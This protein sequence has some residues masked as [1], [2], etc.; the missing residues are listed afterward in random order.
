VVAK[1]L[2]YADA[3]RILGHRRSRLVVALDAVASA[4]LAAWATAA[5][6]G[7]NGADAGIPLN[8]FELKN[9][10][11]RY[12]QALAERTSDWRSGLSR[13]DRT[14]RLAAAH[15]VLV[16]TA[17][18]EALEL[19]E[20][21]V[22]LE[23]LALTSAE[24]VAQATGER[25]PVGYVELIELLATDRLPLPE[26]HRPYTRTRQEVG[27]A[28]TRLAE[29]VASFARGLGLWEELD[30]VKQRRMHAAV[31]GS[32][33]LKTALRLYDDSYRRLAT[34]NHE[35]AMWASL[36]QAHALGAELST[37]A[38]LLASAAER[39][40]GNRTHA[41]LLEINRSALDEPVIS[42]AQAPEGVVLPPLR[43]AY[44]NPSCR[45]AEVNP[46]D[47]PAEHGWW[48]NQNSIPDVETLLA[49]YLVSPRA[50]QA[51]LVV[52]GEPGS[53]KSK[54]TEVLAARL[55]DSDFLPIRVELRTVPAESMIHEQIEHAVYRGPGER[56]GLHDLLEAAQG[57]LPVVMLDGFDE[58][59]QASGV[60]RYDYL[61][62]VR[63]FQR[64]QARIGRPVAVIVTSRTVVADRVRFPI[65]TLAVRLE[66][67][68][69]TQVRRWLDVWARHNTDVLAARGLRPLPAETALAHS[70]LAG[71]PLLLMLLAL[72]DATDNA[73]QRNGAGLGPAELYEALLTDFALREVRRAP[74]NQGLSTARQQE[75]AERE[76][77]RLAVV[78]LSMFSRRRQS[79]TA[80]ELD[81]DLPVLFREDEDRERSRPADDV[82][83]A[84]QRAIGRF[85][86]LHTSEAT[87]RGQPA[88]SYEFLHATFGEFL[89][90]WLTVRA[91][92]DLAAV[93]QVLRRGVTSTGEHLDDGFLHA[94][95]S[96]SGLAERRP[97][98]DFLTELLRRMTDR[99]RAEIR[100]LIPL[101][102]ADS[103][104]PSQ[105]RAFRDYEPVRHPI[106]RRLA[107]YS[108][109][110]TLLL[111]LLADEWVDTAELFEKEP[112]EDWLRH[113]GLWHGQFAK[114]EWDGLVDVVRARILRTDMQLKVILS[115]EDGS[116]VAVRDVLALLPPE[117]SH[118]RT[119]Y[120]I[121]ISDPDNAAYDLA[122]PPAAKSGHMIREMAYLPNW[123]T[124]LL[125]L[126]SI[127]A[128]RTTPDALR[129]HTE[130]ERRTA[131]G[132]RIAELDY[133]RDA[134]PE[135]RVQLYRAAFGA[136]PGHP[137]MREQLLLRLRDEI[138]GLPPALVLDLLRQPFPGRPS[139][140]HLAAV[141]ALWR[142]LNQ[143]GARRD[144]QARD[145]VIAL[146]KSLERAAPGTH[147]A[148]LSPDLL[149][150][151]RGR[152]IR[153][154]A[155]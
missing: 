128:L 30:S 126:H 8:L 60:N 48:R 149:S 44:V 99:E 39:S 94:A 135:R 100:M 145:L 150:A 111:V 63:D 122:V 101:L 46:G 28:H 16:V 18:F 1:P 59:L 142:R 141:D 113:T 105:N 80:A 147:L 69:E 131:P 114:A 125:L 73:L 9:D 52:L 41:H 22:P 70:E 71:Q 91:L 68:G 112:V 84:A 20:P 79:A 77:H 13:F 14:Q 51:P 88:H 45:V 81:R 43:E 117:S 98:V 2:T 103:L 138:P 89:T 49:G 90:A 130:D 11:V 4:G 120:D 85:F 40:P 132:L 50:T 146:V 42:S 115:R 109:N 6:A 87:R 133:A 27:E 12:G 97:T 137:Q 72:F 5:W 78:A 121:L 10:V 106:P 143:P 24:Q 37:V 3:L 58:L 23:E 153:A 86:F 107:A 67:F 56:V 61:E 155:L 110:L 136:L 57:A 76:L 75:L 104:Y 33:T 124:G 116:P 95:L 55:A 25:L 74:Q 82:P 19:A 148:G 53:G 21:P 29:R 36:S 38:D 26:C 96:F 152:S 139:P 102:L 123:R 108:A 119:E 118:I 64:T 140:A 66:P 151:S 32:G 83:T 62:Q 15:A 31:T 54:L 47:A 34:D 154:A 134:A 7:G 127:P 144:P 92:R 65:G 129:W 35:F 93:H 17:Y